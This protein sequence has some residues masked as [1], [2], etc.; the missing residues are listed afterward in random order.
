[1]IL[2]TQSIAHWKRAPSAGRGGHWVKLQADGKDPILTWIQ[3]KTP[4]CVVG[5]HGESI[6]LQVVLTDSLWLIWHAR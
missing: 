4:V 2:D 1:M 5:M 3:S 6:N